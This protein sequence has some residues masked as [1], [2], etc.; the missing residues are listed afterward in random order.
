MIFHIEPV[1]NILSFPVD[2]QRFF[3][4]GIINSF[5]YINWIW[6]IFDDRN[7][8]ISDKVITAQVIEGEKGDIM[9]IF[10]GGSPF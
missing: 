4:D 9:P 5:C 7:Q 8:T 1:P 3:L 10:P 6:A 2:R